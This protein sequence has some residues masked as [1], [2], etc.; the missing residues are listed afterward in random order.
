[1]TWYATEVLA[2]CNASLIAA[3]KSEPALAAHSY[4][5]SEPIEYHLNGSDF[6][7][8]PPEG[9]LLVI[10]PICDPE[11]HCAE[12]HEETVLSWHSLSES[13][14]IEVIPPNALGEHVDDDTLAELPPVT[15][16]AYLKQLSIRTGAHLVFF[17]CFMWGGDTEFE[18]LWLFGERE[19]AAIVVEPGVKS[20]VARVGVGC[21]IHLQ[22]ADLLS[23]A[24]AYLG[25]PLPSPFWILHTRG[26]PWERYK[27]LSAAS[28]FQLCSSAPLAP[29]E[30]PR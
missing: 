25:A 18:Y 4:L 16:L 8:V 5:I 26:F 29:D 15:F 2:R 1:M 7:F 6:T 23:E 27:L 11:T 12:W 28:E 24:L 13:S 21:S 3:V 14:R 30:F 22:Q 20:K 19:E 10:R 9:G 17:H